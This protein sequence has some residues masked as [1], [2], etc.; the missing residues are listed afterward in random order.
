MKTVNGTRNPFAG[1]EALDKAEFLPIAVKF[2]KNCCP[3]NKI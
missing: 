3:H 1:R 2:Q